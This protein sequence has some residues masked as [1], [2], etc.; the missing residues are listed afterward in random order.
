M[1]IE[2]HTIGDV[3]VAEIISSDIVIETAEDGLA[4]L[5]DVYYQGYDRI[6]IYQK[7]ITPDFFNLRTGIAGEILQ[8]FSN[9]R[10]RLVVVGDF[11]QYPGKS[12]QDFIFESNKSGHVNFVSSTSEALNRL[13]KN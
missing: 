2:T 5:G 9:Y 11:A 6:I 4:L 1:Q 3:K 13:S 8:K 12:I 7:N 10:V